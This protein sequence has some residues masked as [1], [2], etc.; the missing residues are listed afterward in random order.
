MEWIKAEREP[1]VIGPGEVHVWR[2]PLATTRDSLITSAE[3]LRADEMSSVKARE[4]FIAS[5]SALRE[6]L[7]AYTGTAPL[8]LDFLRGPHGKPMLAGCENPVEFNLSH[9]GDWGLVAVARVAVG[10]DVEQVRSRGISPNLKE[11]FLTPGERELLELK[12]HEHG[13]TAFFI[14]WSRKEAYLKAAGLGLS[15]PF[16]RIDSSAPQLPDLDERGAPLAGETCW[17]VRDFFVDERHAAAVVARMHE[18]SPTF[19]T[20]WSAHQ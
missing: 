14:I 1:P 16:S 6:L 13:H 7:A 4:S 9:S 15:A 5:Q 20:L 18:L 12:A 2:F 17:S 8:E 19:L 11:R 3:R 10:V